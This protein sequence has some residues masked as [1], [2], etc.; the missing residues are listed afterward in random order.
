VLEAA[1]FSEDT[2][3]TFKKLVTYHNQ[4]GNRV[5]RTKFPQPRGGFYEFQNL[6]DLTNRLQH[7]FSRTPSHNSQ[8][9][10]TLMCFDVASFLLRGAGYGTPRL[11]QEFRSSG[12]VLLAP[13]GPAR[14]CTSYQEFRAVYSH[15]IC[16]EPFFERFVGRPRSEAQTQLEL[17]LVAAHELLGTNADS[18]QNLQDAFAA[19][20]R[21]LERDGFVFTKD[22]QVGLAWFV[23]YNRHWIKPDHAFICLPRNNRFLCLEK[24]SSRGPYLRAEFKSEED[25]GRYH[26]SSYVDFPLKA[27]EFGYG[28]PIAVS[29][30][31]R[32]I[33]VYEPAV[34]P[35]PAQAASKSR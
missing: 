14:A 6:S 5:D 30:G 33:G 22:V 34:L 21:A 17:S 25:V 2:V 9:H 26:S 18:R 20:F 29:L 16:P 8:D 7:P 19:F 31:N 3:S 10:Y 28:C 23:D 4:I 1:G 35:D 13:N 27:G 11:E 24:T 12:I 15:L 32:I